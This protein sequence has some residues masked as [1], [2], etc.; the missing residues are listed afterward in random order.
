MRSFSASTTENDRLISYLK[1]EGVI[2]T[3]RVERAM[4]AVDRALFVPS[5]QSSSAYADHPLPIG[6]GQTIS[7][8]HMVA[9]MAEELMAVE[10]QKVLEIGSGSGYHAAVVSRLILPGG[11]LYSVEV[12][13][14]LADIARENVRRA[15]VQNVEVM[16]GDGSIGHEKEAPYDRIYYTCAAPKVPDRVMGQVKDGGIVLAVVGPAYSTQR[17]VRY[18]ISGGK[19][20]EDPLTYCIFVPLVGELGY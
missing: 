6:C 4:R 10:G 1:A 3:E 20:K 9:I 18:N 15:G 14:K 19:V 16:E 8:P 13:P 2:R 17:L 12:V 5:G 7:A 11:K